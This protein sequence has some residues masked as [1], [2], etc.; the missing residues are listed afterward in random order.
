MARE[1]IVDIIASAVAHSVAHAVISHLEGARVAFPTD[2][3]VRND[4]GAVIGHARLPAD[5]RLE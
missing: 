4:G 1:D 2:A 5:G 3:V